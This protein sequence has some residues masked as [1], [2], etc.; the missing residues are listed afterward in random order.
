VSSKPPNRRG[1]ERYPHVEDEIG[2][3]PARFL[4][5]E[6]L[7]STS[8]STVT[9]DG[10]KPDVRV[11]DPLEFIASRIR[12]IDRLEVIGAWY[13]VER[14][15]IRTPDRGRDQIRELLQDRAAEIREH[16]D[17]DEQLEHRREIVV[18]DDQDEDDEPTVWRHTADDCGS[19]D[20]EKTSSRAWF[21][22]ACEQRTN[23]VEEVEQEAV[24][25]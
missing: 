5:R 12:G 3:D 15:L 10:F 8:L 4:D 24:A 16:G 17:R 21:C 19:T 23:R 22:R 1:R 25:A 18:D 20:V 13:G 14:R 9:R 2:E 11:S 7:T 6:I